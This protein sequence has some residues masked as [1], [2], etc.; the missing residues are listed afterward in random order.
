MSHPKISVILPVLNN[1]QFVDRCIDSVLHQTYED[2]ELMIM[3][4]RCKDRSLKRC[5][6]WQESDERIII[7]SR[8]DSSLSDA[9]NYALPVAKG[10]YLA[11]VDADDWY[12]PEY[13]ATLVAP[14]EA[15]DSIELS[16]C[17]CA[18]DHEEGRKAAPLLPKASG[19]VDVTSETYTQFVPNQAVWIKMFRTEWVR[20]YD[21]QMY[22]GFAEDVSLQVMIAA[23]AQRIYC[24][25]APLYHK[26]FE[27][28]DSVS[29]NF[30][31]KSYLD[32]VLGLAYAV[33]FIRRHGREAVL[34][35]PRLKSIIFS[36]IQTALTCSGYLPEVSEA[37]RAFFQ[38]YYPA[39]AS[40]VRYEKKSLDAPV[41]IIAGA[42]QITRNLLHYMENSSRVR[43]VI[44]NHAHKGQTIGSKQVFPFAALEQEPKDVPILIGST[45]Y[46]YEIAQQLRA[47][48]FENVYYVG[49]VLDE[50]AVQKVRML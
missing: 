5:I 7:V 21:M 1:E 49:D 34:S 26:T 30:L 45:L 16:C 50:E 44:D 22:D 38:K 17:G 2:F 6:A 29:V 43:Y 48:G 47:M 8:K 28:P 40:Q 18:I 24:V 10:K 46:E 25:Q 33:E 14:L 27:N 39:E 3:V 4:G 35:K 37:A 32:T 20:R 41:E 31:K 36:R 23:V 19:T 15:D 13:L 11:Y 12:E 42:G 9:R